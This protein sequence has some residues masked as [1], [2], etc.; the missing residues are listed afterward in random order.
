MLNPFPSIAI[1]LGCKFR[2]RASTYTR[3]LGAAVTALGDSSA[4]L[5]VQ[6][7]DVTTGGL[8]DTGSVGTGVV[9]AK[10]FDSQSLCSARQRADNN[11]SGN[12]HITDGYGRINSPVTAAVGDSVGRHCCWWCSVVVLS[13]SPR[14]EEF[15]DLVKFVWAE[16]QDCAR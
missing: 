1:P 6:N 13:I 16:R 3:E 12:S 7:S 14:E 10:D 4:L 8:D 15:R 5:D 2:F 11:S 9:A